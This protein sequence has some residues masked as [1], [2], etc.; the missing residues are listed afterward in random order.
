MLDNKIYKV[1]KVVE[2]HE[3]NIKDFICLKRKKKDEDEFPDFADRTKE[4]IT[5]LGWRCVEG[6]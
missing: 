5:F 1:F 2:N 3:R 4:R 6:I